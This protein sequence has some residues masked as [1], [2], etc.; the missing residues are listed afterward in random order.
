[1]G[2]KNTPLLEIS[3]LLILLKNNIILIVISGIMGFSLAVVYW[4]NIIP[5]YSVNATIQ[6][7]NSDTNA[8]Y[9]NSNN[10]INN[11]Q[12]VFTNNAPNSD[13]NM[14]YLSLPYVID[15]VIE[16]LHLDIDVQPKLFPI[17]GKYFYYHYS[18]GKE[19]NHFFN[20]KG[21]AWGG[22]VVNVSTLQVPSN[23]IEKAYR[24]TV[25]NNNS[26]AI[27][28]N[29]K[30]I[31]KGKPGQQSVSAD[32]SFQI[33]IDDINAKPG[34]IFF[35]KKRDINTLDQSLAQRLQ[36]KEV[37]KAKKDATATTGIVT[38]S[39][40]GNDRFITQ[41]IIDELINTLS[42]KSS[43]VKMS[44]INAMLHFIDNELPG[45]RTRFADTQKEYA[46]YKE[47]NNITVLDEQ[48]KY[49]LSNIADVEH[50]ITSNNVTLSAL[51]NEYGPKHPVTK[52]LIAQQ[53]YLASRKNSLVVQSAKYPTYETELIRLRAKLDS[54]QQ[55]LATLETKRQ[56]LLLQAARQV[57]AVTILDFPTVPIQPLAPHG[58]VIM[59]VGIILGVIGGYMV[60]I[61]S[62]MFRNNPSAF[63][64]EREYGIPLT[65]IVRYHNIKK[66][67]NQLSSINT[68]LVNLNSQTYLDLSIFI[69][70]LLVKN[71]ETKIYQF[72]SISENQGVSFIASNCAYVMSLQQKKVLL[73]SVR[74]NSHHN[75]VSITEIEEEFIDEPSN[76]RTFVIEYGIGNN[77]LKPYIQK[78]IDENKYE[79]VFLDLLNLH[80][81]PLL[82]TCLGFSS[83][84]FLVVSPYQN[85]ILINRAMR[86]FELN[87]ITPSGVIF[88]YT[89]K[90]YL[91]DLYSK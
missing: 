82:G 64:F 12:P 36:I 21:Y 38:L 20:Y 80:I 17:I 4:L 33:Y 46:E 47:K 79:F 91:H 60:L 71:H 61:I 29:N 30:L 1:M 59:L 34:T 7:D 56:D 42:E 62:W 2:K 78:I 84:R 18:G 41:Q 40:T 14:I 52:A 6:I 26:Y 48:E 13:K 16:K 68:A 88:N 49:V 22:E 89:K 39:L 65:S 76:L 15:P 28:Y 67:D 74:F 86:L 45:V 66:I 3:D 27:T 9:A 85:K 10:L 51:Q 83:N 53:G 54:D 81:H 32:G 5:A 90:Y 19:L 8:S 75:D 11:D 44:E 72:F 43:A 63:F 50:D 69:A 25:I 57:S 58:K 37:T 77:D 24:L 87:Y 73:I 31:V 70:S 23:M 55:L 35:I